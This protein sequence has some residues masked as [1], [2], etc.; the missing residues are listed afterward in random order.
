[1]KRISFLALFKLLFLMVMSIYFAWFLILRY[2]DEILEQCWEFFLVLYNY[3][4]F[5]IAVMVL[6]RYRLRFISNTIRIVFQL[7]SLHQNSTFFIHT[8]HFSKMSEEGAIDLRYLGGTKKEKKRLLE[9]EE[10]ILQMKKVNI[11]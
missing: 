7:F 10:E 8:T 3:V 9:I 6:S 2:F 1:M 4:G 11:D 5:L